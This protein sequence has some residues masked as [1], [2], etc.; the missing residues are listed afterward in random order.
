MARS[1]WL[2]VVLFASSA[3][4]APPEGA[5]LAKVCGTRDGWSDPAPPARVAANTWYVGTCGIT[6]LLVTSDQGHVLIDAGPADAAPLVLANITALGFKPKDVKW[7]L[8]THEHHDHVGALAALQKATGARLAALST[9]RAVVELGQ[10]SA[11]DPQLGT[12]ERLAPVKVDRTLADGDTLELGALTLTVHE[13]PTHSPGSAS[14]TWRAC[15]AKA[16]CQAVA[17]ADSAS[18][19]SSDTYR[20]VDH[21]DRMA[22]ARLG[23]SRISALACDVLITPHPSASRLFERLS[24]AAPLVDADACRTYA[25]TAEARFEERLT[26]ERGA[27]R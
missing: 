17:Y 1:V 22:R 14:W 25:R 16:S 5:Q 26:K 7:L 2:F 24:G 6:V 23:L 10:P 13:T 27:Q 9:A 11:D 12:L 19:I 15:D 3:V 4:A 21:P 18:T 8:F 20:F